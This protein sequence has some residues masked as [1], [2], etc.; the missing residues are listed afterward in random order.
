MKVKVPP[1]K[2]QGIKTKLVPGLKKSPQKLAD[3]GLSLFWEQEL[4]HLIRD[5][6][7]RY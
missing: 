6:K 3:G 1:I 2:S 7:K 5:T 4:W